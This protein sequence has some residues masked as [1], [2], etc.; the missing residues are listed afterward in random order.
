MHIHEHTKYRLL[1]KSMTNIDLGTSYRSSKDKNTQLHNLG[2]Q[3][4]YKS[5]K[6]KRIEYSLEN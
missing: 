3:R 5:H 4:S 1:K 6:E 2:I